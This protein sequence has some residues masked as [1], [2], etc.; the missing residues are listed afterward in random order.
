MVADRKQ[1]GDDPIGFLDERLTQ[2][3]EIFWL[4]K[5]LLCV[6]EPDI[7]RSVLANENDDFMEQS[8]FF[9]SRLGPLQPRELQQQIARDATALIREHLK[10]TD[11]IPSAIEYALQHT[12]WFPNAAAH[13]FLYL[14]RPVLTHPDCA[15]PVTQLVDRIV[16]RAILRDARGRPRRRTGLIFRFRVIHALGNEIRSR[17]ASTC[18]EPRDVLDVIARAAGQTH[19]PDQLAEV[20]LSFVRA[21]VGSLAF[22]LSW[23][24]YLRGRAGDTTSPPH[25][26]IREA[27]RLWPIAWL[28]SRRPRHEIS[29]GDQRVTPQQMVA[30]CPYAI[31]RNPR[32]WPD[33]SDYQPMRW[34]TSGA[35]T[36]FLP[37]GWGDHRCAAAGISLSLVSEI[38]RTLTERYTLGYRFGDDVPCVGV[39]LSPPAF[40]ISAS[41]H[42]YAKR[43]TGD[44][45]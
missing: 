36:A 33:A 7:G 5:T 4:D 35:S 8:D 17:S 39:A 41:P 3:S 18:H 29:I 11:R 23:T 10:G 1:F 2:D 26:A 22:L 32:F 38:L 20:F 37:F 42:G 12:S 6:G 45:S 24:L 14:F 9:H 25:Y 15:K 13:L 44:T 28:S 34:A 21:M 40:E 31:H 16:E 43:K 19:P 30:V 27:L